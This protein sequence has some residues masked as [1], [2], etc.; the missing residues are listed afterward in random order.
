MNRVGREGGSSGEVDCLDAFLVHGGPVTLPASF[1]GYNTDLVIFVYD[2]ATPLS[3]VLSFDAALR[4]HNFGCCIAL[5]DLSAYLGVHVLHETIPAAG[6]KA[7]AS[8]LRSVFR[9]LA[10]RVALD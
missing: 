6:A 7:R 4:L 9:R 3:I 10:P 1:G 5:L 2:G 8:P